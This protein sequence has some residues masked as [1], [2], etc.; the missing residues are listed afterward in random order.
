MS[1]LQKKRG[2]I[3]PGQV[4]TVTENGVPK[5]ITGTGEAVIHGKGKNFRLY[6]K[7]TTVNFYS[8]TDP[9]IS[10]GNLTQLQVPAG[11]IA[12]IQKADGTPDFIEGPQTITLGDKGEQFHPKNDTMP[13]LCEQSEAIQNHLSMGV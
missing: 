3:P 8:A 12:T 4:A 6:K 2:R 1:N 11:A 5:L 10:I 9:V 13:C 7:S